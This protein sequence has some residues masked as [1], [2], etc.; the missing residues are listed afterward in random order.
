[1]RAK[2]LFGA[3]FSQDSIT[4]TLKAEAGLVKGVHTWKVRVTDN[5]DQTGDSDLFSFTIVL[6]ETTAVTTNPTT[7]TQSATPAPLEE[8]A[9]KPLTPA[10]VTK[11]YAE[12]KTPSRTNPSLWID[13]L[14][15]QA[16]IRADKQAENLNQLLSRFIPLDKLQTFN[17]SVQAFTQ[18]MQQKL[19]GW[20]NS[21]KNQII[22]F[23]T[24]TTPASAKHFL[25]FLSS[26]FHNTSNWWLAL[27]REGRANRLALAEQ[28]TN[29]F[30]IS[31]NP[32]NKVVASLQTS[33]FNVIE[34]IQGINLPKDIILAKID[35]NQLALKQGSDR[36][37]T[38]TADFFGRQLNATKKIV[39]S[40]LAGANTTIR[41]QVLKGTVTLVQNT[42]TWLSNLMSQGRENRL[43]LAG[44]GARVASLAVEPTQRLVNGVRLGSLGIMEGLN[45]SAQQKLAIADIHLSEITNNEATLNWSTNHLTYAKVNYGESLMYGQEVF[46]NDYRNQQTAKLVNLK[47]NT[48]YYFEIIVT[49]LQRQQA[50]DAYYS[51]VT[52]GE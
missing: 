6:T 37:A 2:K 5:L 22:A 43:A 38:G 44:G 48:K 9:L 31:F 8:L 25:A 28:G 14:E 29:L 11:Q 50:Y 23:F 13:N 10:E 16:Q 27:M 1:M 30:T 15:K 12:G 42:G 52:K 26:F 17:D 21:L 46:I 34:K 40:F 24:R 18:G 19:A 3:R 51:F 47:S 36:L 33:V 41:Y 49:D 39:V 45:G 4:I 20:F 7:T 35:A 32:V